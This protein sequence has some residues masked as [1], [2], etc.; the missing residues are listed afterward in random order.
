MSIRGA[1]SFSVQVVAQIRILE[2]K[3]HEN[4]PKYVEITKDPKMH[5][6]GFER[7]YS[8]IQN[9][10]FAVNLSSLTQEDIKKK[11]GQHRALKS[12]GSRNKYFTGRKRHTLS[13]E[14]AT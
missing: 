13:G 3:K 12:T 1:L 10:D 6:N 4:E 2:D 7:Q 14:K 11:I 9:Q 8:L 5:S